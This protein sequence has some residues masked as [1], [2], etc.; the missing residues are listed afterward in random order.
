MLFEPGLRYSPCAAKRA[1]STGSAGSIGPGHV[2]YAFTSGRVLTDADGESVVIILSRTFSARNAPRPARLP[3]VSIQSDRG[4]SA[5]SS[6]L[7]IP[8]R[9][10]TFPIASQSAACGLA[11]PGSHANAIANTS[12][13]CFL[14]EGIVL[15]GLPDARRDALTSGVLSN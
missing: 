8:Q 6:G 14:M 13:R 4:T 12:R 10:W 11:V 9:N 2:G 3:D 7:M 5:K 1:F 15:L